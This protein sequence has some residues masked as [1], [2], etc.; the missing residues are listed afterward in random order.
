MGQR[1][2]QGW[3]H[4]SASGKQKYE[5][6]HR[7]G[8]QCSKLQ[9]VSASTQ[10]RW[11]LLILPRCVHPCPPRTTQHLP[12]ISCRWHPPPHAPAP[13]RCATL[14]AGCARPHSARGRCRNAPCGPRALHHPG[15][16]CAVIRHARGRMQRVCVWA[17]LTCQVRMPCVTVCTAVHHPMSA[18]PPPPPLP[19]RRRMG[20]VTTASS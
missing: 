11:K 10:I 4:I 2:V 5:R 3:V 20:V 13:P 18:P 1:R 19:P 12:S 16:R 8:C 15:D 14:T 9:V 7:V 17:C 6:R